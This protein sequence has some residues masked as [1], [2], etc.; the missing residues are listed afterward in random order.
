M[1]KLSAIA[2]LAALT[3]PVAGVVYAEDATVKAGAAVGA[4]ASAAGVDAG[5]NVDATTTSSVNTDNYGTLISTLNAGKGA[6]V[7]SITADADV[8]IILLS[9]L[10]GGGDAQALDN[11]LEKNASAMTTLHA[12]LESNAALKAKLDA[13]K[14]AIEDVV[15]V[16]TDT[17]GKVNI[18]V[19]DRA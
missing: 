11:A 5:A 19:D 12:S 2:I 4:G 17:S 14:I 13:E 9:S 6:D 3:L 1:K 8:S 10:K 16:T 7:A 18:Y 15:A